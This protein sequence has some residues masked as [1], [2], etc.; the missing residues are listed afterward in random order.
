MIILISSSNACGQNYV[1]NLLVEGDGVAKEGVDDVGVVVELLVD[2]EAEE[3]SVADD[4]SITG[5]AFSMALQ[6]H[7]R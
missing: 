4:L 2:H 3:N 6:K 7:R 1:T 5:S